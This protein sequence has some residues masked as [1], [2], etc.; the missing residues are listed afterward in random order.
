[1]IYELTTIHAAA[2]RVKD[3]IARVEAAR[4]DDLVAVWST[5]FGRIND[6]LLLRRFERSAS[7]AETKLLL[8]RADWLSALSAVTVDIDVTQF[9]MVPYVC[10][11]QAGSYGALHEMRTYVFRL[12]TFNELLETWK[13]YL[14]R[15]AMMS[16]APII[17]Y[18]ITGNLQKIVHIWTYENFEQRTL[19]REK[20]LDEG[21]WPA[22]GGAERWLSQENALLKPAIFSPLR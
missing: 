8:G 1:M 4:L 7:N 14:P 22:P 15:R 16:P 3:V 20:A 10:D 11:P 9:Q 21:V 17:M 2:G 19:V 5:E 6:V 18:S 12:G 13:K